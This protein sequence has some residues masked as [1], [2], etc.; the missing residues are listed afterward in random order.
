VSQSGELSLFSTAARPIAIAGST[1]RARLPEAFIGER[2]VI[3]ASSLSDALI[4]SAQ[5]IAIDGDVATLSLL[6]A[7]EG[8]S[9][10]VVIS[11]TGHAQSI[12]VH[13]GLLGAVV[14]AEGHVDARLAPAKDGGSPVERRSIDA[15]PPH[16]VERRLISEAFPTGVRALDALLSCAYGQRLGIFAPAGC[17][18]TSLMAMLI[19]HSEAD[20]YVIALIGERGREVAEFVR[21]KVPDAKRARTVIVHATSDRPAVERRNAALVAMTIAEYFRDQGRRV[22]L[23]ADSITRYARALRDLAL[24]AGQ[25]PAR[26]GYPASVFEDLP[27]LLERPGCAAQGSI[28]ACFTVLLEGESESDPVGEEVRATLDGHIY[29]SP[30]L[31]GAGHFPAIDVLR[32]ASRV[33]DRVVTPEHADAARQLRAKCARLAEIQA[34]LEFGEYRPGEN[35]EVD[36]LL[37]QKPRIDGFLRQ[38]AHSG[39]P[40]DTT[41]ELL[42]E[43]A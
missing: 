9:R 20:V 14:D 2:C 12:V 31:A 38:Q 16:P 11:R 17:G 23:L 24:A 21:E 42:H 30:A 4:G 33:A 39:A 10:D 15:A 7:P 43:L 40:F 27:R 19:D 22:F 1:L 41:L 36:A 29:L 5:V 35:S 37:A 25:L 8:L 13:D 28:T 18:K 34:M 32:S 6:G 3:R 26:R